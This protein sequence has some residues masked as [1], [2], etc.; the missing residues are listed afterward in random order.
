MKSHILV[1]AAGA[2]FVRFFPVIKKRYDYG[3]L[4]FI[5]TFSLVT[6]S[7]YRV[8]EIF[9]LAHQRISTI[10]I[11]AATCMIISVFIRPVW[12]GED[13]HNLIISNIEKLATFLLQGFGGENVQVLPKSND[14]KSVLGTKATE[15]SLANF[16]WWEPGHGCFGFCHPW[17]Q[18]LK[19]GAITRECASQIEVLHC[20]KYSHPKT[21]QTGLQKMITTSCE[22][23]RFETGMALKEIASS[24]KERI[25]L[26]SAFET[27]VQNSNSAMNELASVLDKFSLNQIGGRGGT[28]AEIVQVIAAASVLAEI[29]KNVERLSESA[30]E[31]AKRARFKAPADHDKHD[32]QHQQPPEK[33][34]IILHLGSVKPVSDDVDHV[35]IPVRGIVTREEEPGMGNREIC[36]PNKPVFSLSLTVG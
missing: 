14:Y 15:E 18:Y 35:I 2:T 12:A 27:H 4:I 28:L 13:L 29:I 21:Q 8:E 36:P 20:L 11:G 16:A 23:M 19:I 31:L 5:L 26:S 10:L 6:V 9:E 7:G 25:R 33:S 34:H 1:A 22:R 3:V 24:L 30:N 32:H 17:K